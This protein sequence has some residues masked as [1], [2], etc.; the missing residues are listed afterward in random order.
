MPPFAK[1]TVNVPLVQGEFDYQIPP[2]LLSQVKPGCLVQVPFGKQ[3]V[4][5]VVLSLQDASDWQ[6][7]KPIQAILDEEPVLS[8][9]QLL[10]ARELAAKTFSTLASCIQVMLPPGL[11]QQADTLFTLNSHAQLANPVFSKIQQ[12]MVSLFQERGP[13]RGRQL[14]N[15][16]PRIRWKPS[17]LGLV[18]LGV[19]ISQPV[20]PVSRLKPKMART[21]SLSVPLETGMQRVKEISKGD[22][23]IQRRQSA[24]SYLKK[25]SA[26]VETAWVMASTGCNSQDLQRLS[27][28]GLI[29]FGESE[30]WRDP[31]AQSEIH[32]L[33]PPSLTL[34]Q[35][36]AVRKIQDGFTSSQQG[37]SPVPYLLHG[38]TSS[39]K[40]EIY[41]HAVQEV[42]KLGRQAIILVPEISL[43]P[44]TVNRFL[45]RF[46]GKVGLVH[47][48][49]S[50][51][52]R[53]DTWRR[54]RA[55]LIQVVVGPRS[56]LFTPLPDPGLIVIDECH[57]DSYFQDD[58][59]PAYSAVDAALMY[60]R[61]KKAVIV[62]GS[63]TPPVD[64]VYRANKEGWSML[65]LP[66]RILAHK[67]TIQAELESLHLPSLSFPETG[68]TATLPLPPVEIIDMREEL[69]SGNRSIFSR[70]LYSA[71]EE[72]L[73]HHRQAILFLNRRGSAT[74]VFCRNCGYSLRCPRCDLPLTYH[75]N[76][77][78]LMCHTC[79]YQRNLPIR[80]PVCNST[81]I[82]QYG[83]GTEKVEQTLKEL[84]PSANLLRWDHETTREKGS[85]DL[86]LAH[87]I[88]HNADILIGTQMLAKGLDLP[89]VTLVGVILADVG[90]NLPDYRS[91]ERTF[92]LLTQVAG[93]AGRSPLGGKAILQ[94]FQPEHYAIQAAARHDTAGFYQEELEIRR[95]LGYPPFSKL[96]KIE[97]R[98][99]S[100][101]RVEQQTMA[102]FRQIQNWIEEGKHTATEIIGPAPCFFSR[103]NGYYRWQII[104][105]GPDPVSILRGKS[106]AQARV[107]VD[108][109]SLL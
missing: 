44:Q 63:A 38:V 70:E 106:I 89:L 73:T 37:G 19:L 97:F 93:R 48:K 52:E 66:V 69:K 74:Y 109:P 76:E 42:L 43:T 9:A 57:D 21:V 32:S 68:L 8:D 92:Q 11:S 15:A 49:L 77:S 85:H 88:R 58:S 55:G 105:R 75:T 50:P 24:L 94:T 2:E 71:L 30:I 86:I 3:S 31:L 20:L 14:E 84:F 60:A 104:L 53:Y 7:T 40:T 25:E 90:L 36:D 27:D 12:R 56:A 87:F 5:G 100:S 4:Q 99:L 96:V 108:P 79:G 10:L 65:E 23:V 102:A 61:I 78:K 34:E 83:M 91:P 54:A 51:G 35:K 80:C 64:L 33:P 98:D 95:K 17:A 72:T 28:A 16:F 18:K 6:E 41:L 1:V 22:Q 62:L 82:K 26:P 47:S 29:T 45:S 101:Q 46:P 67:E 107:V 13:L 81:Q 39:G 103:Q 59:Q